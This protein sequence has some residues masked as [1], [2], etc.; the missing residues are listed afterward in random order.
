MALSSGSSR[1]AIWRASATASRHWARSAPHQPT[2]DSKAHSP[3]G[4][5]STPTAEDRY[6]TRPRLDGDQTYMQQARAAVADRVEELQR[7]LDAHDADI[8]NRHFA[9]DVLWG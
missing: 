6:L 5:R 3:A 7:G 8:A 9:E 1:W 2:T 4:R